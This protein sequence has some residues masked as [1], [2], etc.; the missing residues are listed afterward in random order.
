M[1]H[2]GVEGGKA[3]SRSWNEEKLPEDNCIKDGH[4]KHKCREYQVH[5][6]SHWSPYWAF[7]VYPTRANALI[8]IPQ[9]VSGK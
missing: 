8:E 3:Y 9:V 5:D 7:Y 2:G 4:N 1:K 6:E